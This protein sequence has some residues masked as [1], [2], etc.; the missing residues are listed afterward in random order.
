MTTLETQ[1]PVGWHDP[2]W[3]AL[4]VGSNQEKRVADGLDCRHIE[5]YLPC[6][7]SARQWKDRRVTLKMPLFPGYIFVKIALA[8]RM[9]VLT[10]PRTISLVCVGSRPAEILEEEIL[11]VQLGIQHGNAELSPSL[12]EGQRVMITSGVMSGLQGVLLRRQNSTR[13]VISLDSISRAFAVEVDSDSVTII[14][15]PKS[16]YR[17]RLGVHLH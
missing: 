15:E 13:V 6:I 5:H 8:E 1:T 17:A 16:A 7:M 10:V 3:Y 2:K 9:R 14:A 4:L 12:K 11:S